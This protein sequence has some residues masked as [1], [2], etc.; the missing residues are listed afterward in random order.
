MEPYMFWSTLLIKC[1]AAVNILYINYFKYKMT[2]NLNNKQ[3]RR[4]YRC[5]KCIDKD[6]Y[7]GQKHRVEGHIW[8]LHV[9]L[10]VVPYYC[11]L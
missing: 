5:L 2:D 10:E 3:I 4:L 1:N 6:G 9:P 8:K 11:I 7:V